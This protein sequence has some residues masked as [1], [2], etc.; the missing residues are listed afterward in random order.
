MK[1]SKAEKKILQIS[2]V[3]CKVIN[4]TQ[5][6]DEPEIILIENERIWVRLV[7]WCANNLVCKFDSGVGEDES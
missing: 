5:D 3:I 4:P 7:F 2:N 6:K 1:S